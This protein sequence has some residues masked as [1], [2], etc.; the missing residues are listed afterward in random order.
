MILVTTPREYAY[1]VRSVAKESLRQLWAD[2]APVNKIV[3]VEH[4]VCSGV[5]ADIR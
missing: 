1:A 3:A 5:G 4:P 2:T